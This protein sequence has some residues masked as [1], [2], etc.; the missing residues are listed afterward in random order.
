MIRPRREAL[1]LTQP[2]QTTVLTTKAADVIAF[3]VTP[4]RSFS[5][6]NLRVNI[7][8]LQPVTVASLP[9]GELLSL[10]APE[11]LR[12]TG[13]A[14]GSYPGGPYYMTSVQRTLVRLGRARGPLG[15]GGAWLL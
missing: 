13:D 9:G 4:S 6:L 8:G 2:P 10:A 15:L 12:W 7:N 14:Y 1:R 3:A 5:E 11:V